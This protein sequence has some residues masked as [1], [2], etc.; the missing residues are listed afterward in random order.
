MLQEITNT[1]TNSTVKA[2]VAN[3]AD[4]SFLF[5]ACCLVF[6][7]TP[8]LG[9]FYSGLVRQKNS[10]ATIFQSVATFFV[11]GIQWW[12]FGFSFA[13]GTGG[14]VGAFIGGFDYFMMM[15]NKLAATSKYK[16]KSPNPII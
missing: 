7:M 1:T 5:T 6:I 2:F 13:F 16:Y 10:A 11:V 14:P 9:F 12:F 4:T 8:G 15:D 3:P